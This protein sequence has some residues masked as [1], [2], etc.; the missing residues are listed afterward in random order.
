MKILLSAVALILTS[1]VYA[2]STR[3]L[4]STATAGEGL[5]RTIGTHPYA[6][7]YR[8][9]YMDQQGITEYERYGLTFYSGNS[10]GLGLIKSNNMDEPAFTNILKGIQMT[11]VWKNGA[12]FIDQLEDYTSRYGCIPKI[13]STSHGWLSTDL[14][15]EVHGLSGYRGFNGIYAL[16]EHRPRGFSQFGTRTIETHMMRSIREG[17]IRFCQ[18]CVIQIYACNVSAEFANVFAQA[19]GCQTVVATGQGSPFFQ[20]MDSSLERNR[21]HSAFHYWLSSAATWA[22]RGR[23]GWHRATP[24]KNRNGQVVEL[25]K[26]NLGGQYIAL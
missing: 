15:G 6:E 3:E 11:G 16:D 1:S 9:R 4:V 12:S 10:R 23:V 21:T 14:T 17:K 5:P 2:Q 24:V 7:E 25:I 13:T 19:S 20:K 8:Q 26:E 18:T 22:E